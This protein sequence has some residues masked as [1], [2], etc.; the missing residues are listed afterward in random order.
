MLL[1]MLLLHFGDD[2]VLDEEH[3]D[4]PFLLV[5]HIE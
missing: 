4:E 1:K 3:H 5:K 2:E